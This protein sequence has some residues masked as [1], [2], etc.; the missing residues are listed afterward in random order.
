MA[1]VRKIGFLRGSTRDIC[2]TDSNLIAANASTDTDFTQ[3][4]GRKADTAAT[5]VG[6]TASII[7]MLKYVANLLNGTRLSVGS[8]ITLVA[9]GKKAQGGGTIIATATGSVLIKTV[10]IKKLTTD[11]TTIASL[12]LVTDD[13]VPMALTLRKGDGSALAFGDFITSASFAFP[14]GWVLATG[15]I[16]KLKSNVNGEV[17]NGYQI[18]VVAEA[19]SEAASL[20]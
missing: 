18:H 3:G 16:L 8:P 4:I 20:A 6:T 15:K 5:A 7:A 10:H 14:V 11:E 12:S 17:T 9:A 13:A 2:L 19:L 1:F